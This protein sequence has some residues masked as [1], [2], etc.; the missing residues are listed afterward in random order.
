MNLT[1]LPPKDSAPLRKNLPE[2]QKP[3]HRGIHWMDILNFAGGT[4]RH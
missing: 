3:F 4:F 1:P 2:N